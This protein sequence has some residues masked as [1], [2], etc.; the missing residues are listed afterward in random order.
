MSGFNTS[1]RRAPNVSQ[2]IANLNTIPSPLAPAPNTDFLEDEL[3]LFATTEFFDFDMSEPLGGLN[4]DTPRTGQQQRQQTQSTIAP[5]TEQHHKPATETPLYPSQKMDDFLG[6]TSHL[7]HVSLQ[8][9]AQSQSVTSSLPR[10]NLTKSNPTPNHVI[11]RD[12]PPPRDKRKAASTEE[13]SRLAAEEDKRRRNTAAS[14][15]FRIKKKEREKALETT[16]REMTEKASVLEARVQQ[17]EME[18]K[19]L[20][21]LITERNEGGKGFAEVLS[22]FAKGMDGDV[23]GEGETEE[24]EA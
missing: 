1:T 12:A 16:A 23:E 18:N 2:Y 9:Q 5:T 4:F 11:S 24:E 7:F 21:G 15:R 17:L 3:N 8:P 22:R 19:W 10:T 14:A 13:A 6:G 20:K